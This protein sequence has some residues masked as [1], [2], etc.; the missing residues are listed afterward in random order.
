MAQRCA[1]LKAAF[2]LRML[3][4][5]GAAA[6]GMCPASTQHQR[7]APAAHRVLL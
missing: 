4:W 6:L 5:E 3:G 7:M 1:Q 2:S